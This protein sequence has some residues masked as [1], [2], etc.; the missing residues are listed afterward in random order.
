MFDNSVMVL[1]AAVAGT[2]FLAALYHALRGARARSRLRRGYLENVKPLFSGGLKAIMPTG[3]PRL[4]GTY[5]GHEFD[6][7][8]VADTL[9]MRKLPTLWLLV[10]LPDRLPVGATFDMM[11]RPRGV[12]TFSRLN[13]LPVQITN[14]GSFPDDCTIR[15]DNPAGLPPRDLLLRHLGLFADQRA[16]EL[17]ISP[18]GLRVVWLADEAHRGKY[19]LFRDSEMGQT[20]LKPEELRPLLDY[21]IAVREDV[22]AHANR[23]H[24]P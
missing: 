24:Q 11:M 16:K 4:S 2:M 5:R 22:L 7:Q 21:L 3:F 9:N 23:T 12:E 20:P 13:D 14:D 19:L 8:V 15:T 17:V 1:M 10:T 18:K 6:L